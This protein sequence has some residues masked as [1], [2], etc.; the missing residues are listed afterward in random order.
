MHLGEHHWVNELILVEPVGGD[1]CELKE[2]EGVE[3]GA[4]AEI[5]CE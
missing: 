4:M 1:E 5:E 2:Q 3:M